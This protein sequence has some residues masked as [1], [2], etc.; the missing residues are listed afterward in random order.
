MRKLLS[1]AFL[2]ALAAAVWF[3]ARWFVHRG[4]I[5][6]T[7]VFKDAHGIKR[8]DPVTE[9]G[10]PIGRV[11]SVDKL[12]DQT[13]VTVRIDR[14]H[15]RSVVSDSLIAVDHHAVVVSNTFAVGAPIDDGAIVHPREDGISRF[16]AKHGGAVKPYLDSARAKA[17]AWIDDHDFADWNA[18]V[19]E[20]KREGSA[21]FEKHLDELKKK[22][23]QT[24][25]SM[26]D[27]NHADEARKLKDKFNR[28]L[29][30]VK[31]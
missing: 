1:L 8:G 6:A 22:V 14:N 13:A 19:P 20:W 24:S 18:K 29:T 11:V 10:T 3:G 23:E 30:Q 16:L 15:R 5:K 7:I 31:N 28:W 21:A 25:D 9:G 12:D 2:I 4:E 26:K 17:D 27:S